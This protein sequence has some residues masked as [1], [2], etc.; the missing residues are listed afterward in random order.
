MLYNWN[1]YK[2]AGKNFASYAAGA[3]TMLVGVHLLTPTQATDAT[4][5]INSIVSGIE[6]IGNLIGLI[7]GILTLVYT[8]LKSAYNASPIGQAT[9][10]RQAVPG[11]T[12]VTT[13]EIAAAIPDDNVIS[14]TEVKV[15]PK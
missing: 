6:A 4:N 7:T 9:G 5:D 10:L 1:S 13:P 3:V 14:N 11:T 8:M 2:A 15:I 12:I